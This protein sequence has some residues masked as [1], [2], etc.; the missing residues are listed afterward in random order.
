MEGKYRGEVA[1]KY[2]ISFS[3]IPCNLELGSAVT[4]LLLISVRLTQETSRKLMCVSFTA[5]LLLASTSHCLKWLS[6]HYYF[7]N[8]SFSVCTLLFQ[9]VLFL[10][11]QKIQ[12]PKMATIWK[13]A[14][15]AMLHDHRQVSPSNQIKWIKWHCTRTEISL[16]TFGALRQIYLT[17]SLYPISQSTGKFS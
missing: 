12:M 3:L 17:G 7:L 6:F 11:L 13:K 14:I 9:I 16:Q 4:P 1:L 2:N 5:F 10:T 8:F 15:C